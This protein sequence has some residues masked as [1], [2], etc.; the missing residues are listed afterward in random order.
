MLCSCHPVAAIRSAM[1][2]PSGRRIRASILA[3]LLVSGGGAVG[4]GSDAGAGAPPVAFRGRESRAG[5]TEPAFVLAAGP[6]AWVFLVVF[7]FAL[8][9]IMDTPVIDRPPR[10]CHHREPQ[11]AEPGRAR[12]SGPRAGAL[13]TSHSRLRG[14]GSPVSSNAG[15]RC[16][17]AGRVARGSLDPVWVSGE[18]DEAPMAEIQHVVQDMNSD[19]HVGCATPVRAAAQPVTHHLLQLSMAASARELSVYRDDLC[20]AMPARPC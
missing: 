8:V 15:R 12:P 19:I 3:F 10:R 5:A 1:A 17:T 4:A 13:R 9:F 16:R 18:A 20:R 7:G 2:V 14:P 11:P 6:R